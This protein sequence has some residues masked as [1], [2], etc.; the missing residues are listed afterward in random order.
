VIP[1]DQIITN[2]LF[3]AE[4]FFIYGWRNHAGLTVDQQ[5]FW[6]NSASAA[7]EGQLALNFGRLRDATI[8][9][10]LAVARSDP[11][12]AKRTAA[13]EDINRTMAKN[14][15]QIPTTWTLWGT[16]H[17]DT[18]QGLGSTPLPDGGTFRDG[19]GFSGQFWMTAMWVKQG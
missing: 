17:K 10:D 6:W 12:E 8:D 19:A 7:P 1:Q 13:A 18:V 5:N 16:P 2:A 9:A 3:G 4:N 11:D 14:C 15:Y